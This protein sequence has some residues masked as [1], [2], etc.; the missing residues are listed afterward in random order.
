MRRLELR[1]L[2]FQSVAQRRWGTLPGKGFAHVALDAP[3][4]FTKPGIDRIGTREL[5]MELLQELF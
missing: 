3:Q 4:P 1:D 5:R 2:V